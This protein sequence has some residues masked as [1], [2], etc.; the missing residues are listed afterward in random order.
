MRQVVTAVL[1]GYR[2]FISPLMGPPCRIYPTCSSNANDPI[3]RHGIARGTWLAL[4]RLIR[5]N[6]WNPGGVD[7]VPGENTDN[8]GCLHH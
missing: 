1:R 3:E 5:C 6:P 4:R 2:Y 7:M 8:A